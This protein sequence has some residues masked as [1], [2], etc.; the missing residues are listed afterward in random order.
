MT[1]DGR[2][3]R[4]AQ[5]EERGRQGSWGGTR[6][7][8]ACKC[9]RNTGGESIGSGIRTRCSQGSGPFREEGW[10]RRLRGNQHAASSNNPACVIDCEMNGTR[11]WPEFSVEVV[12][13]KLAIS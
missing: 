5:E 6:G 2:K 13:S 10:K 4:V 9:G 8:G 11:D 7:G 3:S 12:D 1:C